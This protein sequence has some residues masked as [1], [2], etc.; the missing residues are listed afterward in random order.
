MFK[1]IFLD[2]SHS[3]ASIC[4]KCPD[5]TEEFSI[6]F[7]V[8]VKNFLT[9]LALEY[10]TTPKTEGSIHNDQDREV[11]KNM[12]HSKPVKSHYGHCILFVNTA[13]NKGFLNVSMGTVNVVK[14][15]AKTIA[16]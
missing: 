14:H 11:M 13:L 2:R 9:S 12:S 7:W 4:L 6:K 1:L 8:S 3:R 15:L 10:M 16:K 5:K